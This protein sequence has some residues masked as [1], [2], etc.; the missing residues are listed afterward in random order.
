MGLR[1]SVEKIKEYKPE[2][3]L[4]LGGMVDVMGDRPVEALWHEFD[5]ITNEL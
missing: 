5:L 3:V 4:F 1:S 2:F